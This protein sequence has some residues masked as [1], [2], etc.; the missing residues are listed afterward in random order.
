MAVDASN[1]PI[2]DKVD[3]LEFTS[4]RIHELAL[5]RWLY[6]A[7]PLQEGGYPTPVIFATPKDAHAEFTRTFQSAQNP[8]KYL[9][10]IKDAKGHP[11]YNPHP[12]NVFYP[13]ISVKRTGWNYRPSQSYGYHRNRRMFWPTSDKDPT[14]VR[15]ENLGTAAGN[16]MPT[17]WDF[18]FQVDY[19]CQKP[20]TMSVFVN[21]LQRKL[22]VSG[23]VPQTFIVARYPFPHGKQY[24]RMYLDGGIQSI[25]QEGDNENNQEFRI[26]FTLCVEGYAVDF[27]TVFSPVMWQ[28]G[29]GKEAVTMPPDELDRYFDFDVTYAGLDDVRVDQQNPAIESRPGLPPATSA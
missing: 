28:I 7:F 13:L 17:A 9:L 22:W 23:G 18:R 1:D 8:F 21:R 26:S 19:L 11:V 24:L 12:S 20:Q 2:D 3:S 15:L 5:Q 4:V 27:R 14:L 25:T 10:E 16:Q 29:I 6:K